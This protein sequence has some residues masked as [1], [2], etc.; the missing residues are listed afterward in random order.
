MQNKPNILLI[1]TDQ[2]NATMMSC[3]G[4]K[5]V[6][7]PAMDSL[8]ARGVRFERAYCT[9]PVCVP[10]RFSLMTGRY[11]SEIGQ[12]SNTKAFPTEEMKQQGLGWLLQSAGYETIYGGKEHLPGMNAEDVGF[13]YIEKDERDILAQTCADYLKQPKTKP[14]CLVASFINPHDICHMAI[15]EFASTGMELW[16]KENCLVEG[17]TVAEAKQIPPH[18]TE[19]EFFAKY[20]PP[21][22]SNFAIQENEPQAIKDLINSRS[23]RERAREDWTEK[24]WRIHR[25]AYL[26]L[27]QRVDRQIQTVLDALKE[28]G[29]EDDT[30]VIFTSDHG[31]HDSAHH[32]EHKTVPYE[33]AARIP[34]IV[35]QPGLTDHGSVNTE[36]IVSNGL[37]LLPTLCDYAGAEVP[38]GRIGKSIRPIIEG[39]N[40]KWREE[41]LIECEIGRALVSADYKYILYDKGANNEQLFDLQ[42][43]PCEIRN[44]VWDTG[45]EKI[46]KQFRESIAKYQSQY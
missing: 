34:F 14:F 40:T 13:K 33:E 6:R 5:Y 2:Q 18:L 36:H 16:W 46:L 22:P 23:F 42:T 35:C 31:D 4:N 3:S 8:A 38:D 39:K 15:N 10:S 27:T 21:L 45:K 12:W 44:S 24:D 30:L 20:C 43:D 26:Q 11:P 17:K 1:L 19:E 41:L 7:T 25:W 9:N 32:L 29:L 37:D 28:S